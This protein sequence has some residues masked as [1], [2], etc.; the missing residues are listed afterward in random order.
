[1]GEPFVSPLQNRDSATIR[2]LLS[3]DGEV[4]TFL[5]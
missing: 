5:E 3:P 2:L 1:M 4:K